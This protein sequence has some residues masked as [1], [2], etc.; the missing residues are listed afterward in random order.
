M[1]IV[2]VVALCLTSLGSTVLLGIIVHL[3]KPLKSPI[4]DVPCSTNPPVSCADTT[5]QN[6]TDTSAQDVKRRFEEEQK[7]F[8]QLMSYSADVAYGIAHNDD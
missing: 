3:Y 5:R 1:A 4:A 7:A 2:A 8:Q 6:T